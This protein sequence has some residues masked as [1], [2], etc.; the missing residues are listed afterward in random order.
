VAAILLVAATAGTGY[1]QRFATLEERVAGA[2]EVVVATARSVRAE[3]RTNGFGDRLIVSRVELDVAEH[4]K[5]TGAGTLWMDLEGGTLDGL[6]LRV[7]SLP[8][9]EAGERAVFFVNRVDG[10]AVVPY[11]RGQGI[12][13]LEPDNV[14]RGSTL[15][16]DDIRN[17]VRAQ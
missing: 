14:V 17:R 1:G 5:G 16:L 13:F 3:W 11:L 15:R 6:T 12:L 2:D 9:I 4:L 8:L 10:G 7:S